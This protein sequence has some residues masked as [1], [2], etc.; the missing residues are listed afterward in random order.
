M[1][2]HMLLNTHFIFSNEASI[3]SASAVIILHNWKVMWTHNF[4]NKGLIMTLKVLFWNML[5]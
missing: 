4:R 1:N 2:M 5:I 3:R